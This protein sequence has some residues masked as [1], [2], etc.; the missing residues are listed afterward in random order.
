MDQE[1]VYLSRPHMNGSEQ[2]YVDAVLASNWVAPL[3]PSVELFEREL[4]RTVNCE[5]VLALSSGTA[6]IHL[7][8][9]LLGVQEGDIVFCSSLT[10]VASVNPVLYLNATPVFIDSEPGTWNMSPQALERAFQDAARNG[11]LPKAVI[12]VQLFG[13]NADMDP[14]ITL[15]DF[16]GVPIVEDAA[17]S[18][19]ATYKDAM[20]GTMGRFGI[21][22]F[23]GNKI[24]TT[25]G[26]GAL[27]SKD[28]AALDKARYWASQA[29]EPVKHYEHV[30]MGYN[31]RLSSILAAIGI[32][33]LSDLGCRVEK[34]RQIYSRYDQQLSGIEGVAMMPEAEMGR[35]TRWLTALTIDPEVVGITAADIVLRMELLNIECRQVWKPMHLQPLFKGAAYYEH[36]EGHSVSDKLFEH[37]ICLPSGSGLTEIQQERVVNGLLTCLCAVVK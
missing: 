14:I 17:E 37:G 20:S 25:S 28:A 1:R 7:A 10:F 16:Y 19:G 27:V 11:R 31:Y 30:E 32:A 24:I 2:H 5:G 9:R 13:Q 33:Q 21:Y 15:C 26:G 3:G 29:R 35:A 23:N 4:A 22:S 36:K 18:L 6:A 12:V 8:L 34:R